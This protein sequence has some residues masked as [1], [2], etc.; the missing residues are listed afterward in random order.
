MTV[1]PG[2]VTDA[3]TETQRALGRYLDA[4]WSASA[5]DLDWSCRQTGIHVADSLL[6]YAAQIIG[7]DSQGYVSF[8]L[9]LDDS[10]GPG[11]LL[12]LISICGAILARTVAAADPGDRA[13]HFYGISDPEGFAAMG[14]LETL[15]HTYDIAGGLKI[16]WR[17]PG[18]LCAPVLARLFPD[19]PE[20]DPACVLLWC[21]GRAALD[22]RPRQD[23]WRWDATVRTEL[24]PG[25]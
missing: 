17:P 2:L 6:W 12:R 20:G 3:V 18:R 21:T 22:D 16:D 4:D 15:V 14:V 11:G 7:K 9:K 1:E 5:L 24:G 13:F 23:G 19:A 10:E 25:G 8:E